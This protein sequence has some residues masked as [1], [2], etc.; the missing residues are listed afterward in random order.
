MC[1]RRFLWGRELLLP[2]GS[3]DLE[4]SADSLYF[5]HRS[6][7][8]LR[9][10]KSTKDAQMLS[11]VCNVMKSQYYSE[12][13]VF[14]EGKGRTF[15]SCWVHHLNFLS[16]MRCKQGGHTERTDGHFSNSFYLIMHIMSYTRWAR[17]ARIS[18]ICSHQANEEPHV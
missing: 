5:Y 10:V 9:V 11:V 4:P 18:T 2:I 6:E 15:E 1:W 7:L 3:R 14:S 13:V 8:L 17:P 12:C 16:I